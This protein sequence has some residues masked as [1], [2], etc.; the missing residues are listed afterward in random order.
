ML[1]F[2]NASGECSLARRGSYPGSARRYAP[3]GGRVGCVTDR[4]R[5]ARSAPLDRMND[6]SHRFCT[7]PMMDAM[8]IES[9]A[10]S[11]GANDDVKRYEVCRGM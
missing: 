6:V 11:E 7:A 9:I 5:T 4:Y 10:A 8:M 2:R 3:R 1:P